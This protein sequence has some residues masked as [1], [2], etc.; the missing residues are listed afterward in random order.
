MGKRYVKKK[1]VVFLENKKKGVQYAVDTLLDFIKENRPKCKWIILFQHDNYPLSKSFFKRLSNLIENGIPDNISVLG[2]NHLD[3]GEYTYNGLHRF[4]QGKKPLGIL[5]KCHLSIKHHKKRW[6]AP[7][8]N[9]FFTELPFFR[10]Y[11]KH[12]KNLFYR[13]SIR[14]CC[15]N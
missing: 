8:P 3:K 5:G 6:A 11:L 12:F 4:K 1:N 9:F 10:T 13:D 14:I 2:F 7:R 15:W